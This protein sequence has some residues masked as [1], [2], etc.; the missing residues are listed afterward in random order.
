MVVGPTDPGL[1][2]VEARKGQEAT[3]LLGIEHGH[4]PHSCGSAS[5]PIR[6]KSMQD[7]EQAFAFQQFGQLV[8]FGVPKP[9]T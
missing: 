3:L 1:E 8:F 2:S 4:Q 5:A 7:Q 6:R 9:L